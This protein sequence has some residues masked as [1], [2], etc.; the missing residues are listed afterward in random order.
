MSK[1]FINAKVILFDGII[2]SGAVRV[3]GEKISDIYEGVPEKRCDDEIIDVSGLY[4]SPG[5]IDVHVH[6]GG[7]GYFSGA[8]EEEID[9]ACK[10]HL[11]HG[12]TA[13]TY[14]IATMPGDLIVKAIEKIREYVALDRVRP[15]YLGVDLEGPYLSPACCGAMP[16][17][18][19]RDPD[20]KEYIP[21]FDRFPEIIRM[22]FAPELDGADELSD[23]LVRRGIIGSI[24]HSDAYFDDV[25]KVY[26]KGIRCVTHLYSLTSTVRRRNA[27]RFAGTLEAAYL[28]D[29]MWVEVI[30]DG[31]HL[32]A[33]LLKLIYKIKGADKILLI[34]DA[35][36][37][38]GMTD[39]DRPYYT[40]LGDP[41][42]LEDGVAKLPSREAFAGSIATMDRVVRTMHTLGEVPLVH[43]VRMASANPAR[44][45]GVY[46]K[47][48]S[49]ECGKDADLL[50]FDENVNVKS[51]YVR[52]KEVFS[53]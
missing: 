32:P 15:D 43:A 21:L 1:L 23:E 13:M 24:G 17:G 7:G 5:F 37:G 26:D 18:Y 51:V 20:P 34:T 25:M 14:C 16:P 8:D 45:L 12:T 48:G 3:D 46:E 38:G 28:H 30:A 47:K 11:A 27:Y 53:L 4:L 22:A 44:H 2:E 40:W 10:I 35:T 36:S 9:A 50:I 29:G 19:V 6:G 41:I 39:N 52:G 33:P 31:C 49:I 42:I